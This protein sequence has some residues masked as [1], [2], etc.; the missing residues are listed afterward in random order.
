MV[1]TTPV[2]MYSKEDNIPIF[3]PAQ[4]AEIKKQEADYPV[5]LLLDF[6]F[7]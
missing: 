5:C 6:C 7:Y 1:I 3:V 2:D 4:E